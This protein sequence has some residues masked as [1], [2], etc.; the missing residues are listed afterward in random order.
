MDEL[1]TQTNEVENTSED[2]STNLEEST[3]VGQSEASVEQPEVPAYQPTYKFKVKDQELE[4]DDMF[5][6]LVTSKEAEAKIREFHE[7]YH[8]IE[9]VKKHR[10]EIRQNWESYRQNYEPVLN[11]LKTA[12]QLYQRG[13]MDAVLET[14]GMDRNA[15]LEWS[16][17][18][19]AI[20]SLSPQARAEY[21]RQRQAEREG[22]SF[23]QEAQTY[24]EQLNQLR[25][26]AKISEINQALS[27]PEAIGLQQSFDQRLGQG[28][29]RKEMIR[30][31]QLHQA[32]T[33]EDKHAGEI[34]KEMIDLFGYQASPQAQAPTQA[35]APLKKQVPVIPVTKSSG[36]SSVKAM[37]KTFDEMIKARDSGKL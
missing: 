27:S 16:R 19:Q 4:F 31:G 10:D 13:D 32:Q 22:Y 25:R 12:S 21:D 26:E 5:K 33:G 29:F 8:G 11:Q 30:R 24:R 14:L 18:Q 23:Q 1:E 2:V 28:A 36:S 17:R 37:P 15:V 9:E 7:K 34:L 35:Q 3:Q 6:P 20:E